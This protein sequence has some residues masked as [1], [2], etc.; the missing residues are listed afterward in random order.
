M[1]PANEHERAIAGAVD[2]KFLSIIRDMAIS[3]DFVMSPSD[4][5]FL[6]RYV[7]WRL[8]H[9]ARPMAGIASDDPSFTLKCP[10]CGLSTQYHLAKLNEQLKDRQDIDFFCAA[11]PRTISQ[12]GCENLG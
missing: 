6:V 5:Q 12:V 1:E 4:S 3:L 10:N 7:Q 9:P 11:V 8:D 2:E